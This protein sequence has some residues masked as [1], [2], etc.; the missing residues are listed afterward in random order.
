MLD[1]VCLRKERGHRAEADESKKELHSESGEC[2]LAYIGQTIGL[3]SAAIDEQH[4][5]RI[6]DLMGT[7]WQGGAPTDMG[8]GGSRRFKTGHAAFGAPKPEG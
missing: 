1:T 6:L 3:R 7:G 2:E 5:S 8:F 4:N